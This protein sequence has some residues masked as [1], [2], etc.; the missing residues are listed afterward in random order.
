MRFVLL[1]VLIPSV[2]AMERRAREKPTPT[3]LKAVSP[4]N[5]GMR[6]LALEDEALRPFVLVVRRFFLLGRPGAPCGRVV[7][8]RCLVP[9]ALV[10]DRAGGFEGVRRVL[11]WLVVG[12]AA[13]PIEG[14]AAGLAPVHT[15]AWPAFDSALR[16]VD[17]VCVDSVDVFACD[18][19]GIVSRPLS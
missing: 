15:E 10:A 8:A 16:A 14:L 9:L 2:R 17:L 3:R 1:F 6:C 4:A 18:R 11:D 13:R 5:K 19:L 12:R 7:A